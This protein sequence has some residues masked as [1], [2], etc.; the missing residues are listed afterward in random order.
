MASDRVQC[1]I[2]VTLE[3]ST[4][5][6]KRQIPWEWN[7]TQWYYPGSFCTLLKVYF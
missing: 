5:G 2:S 3:I 1:Q 4:E 6:S 7:W